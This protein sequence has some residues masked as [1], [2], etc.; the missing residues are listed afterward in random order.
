[1]KD[2][3]KIL[4]DLEKVFKKHNI[5]IEVIQDGESLEVIYSINH[6]MCAFIY[7]HEYVKI[8]GKCLKVLANEVKKFYKKENEDG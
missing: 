6:N 8:D 4:N 2:E 7:K 1:M 5:S 3:I